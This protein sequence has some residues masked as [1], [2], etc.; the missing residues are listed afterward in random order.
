MGINK[1]SD[2]AADLQIGAT[3]QG[4]VRLYISSGS[5]D[6]PMDFEPADAIEIA[7]EIMAAAEQ[8]RHAGRKG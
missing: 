6:L 3:D 4:M 2:E 1:Q 5:V 8:A 7:E